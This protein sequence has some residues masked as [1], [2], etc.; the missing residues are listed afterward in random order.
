MLPGEGIETMT[1][2]IRNVSSPDLHFGSD[3]AGL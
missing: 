1:K 3:I 2:G